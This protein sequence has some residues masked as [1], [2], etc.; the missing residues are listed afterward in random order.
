MA[1][2]PCR[3]WIA[4]VTGKLVPSTA[5]E[6]QEWLQSGILLC[7]LVNRIRPN[8]VTR[9]SNSVMPFKQMENINSYIQAVI[10]LGVPTQ[11]RAPA[12]PTGAVCPTVIVGCAPSAR[13]LRSL[14]VAHGSARS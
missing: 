3:R 8:T 2:P 14:T 10:K 13:V 11:V 5:D 7:E 4:A 12:A 1:A 6:M 9:I